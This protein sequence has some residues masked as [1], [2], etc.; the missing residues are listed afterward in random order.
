V[1]S[2]QHLAKTEALEFL[3]RHLWLRKLLKRMLSVGIGFDEDVRRLLRDCFHADDTEFWSPDVR[4]AIDSSDLMT[5]E[6]HTL[7]TAMTVTSS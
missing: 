4:T 6:S 1:T 3:L 7:L 2:I 5:E